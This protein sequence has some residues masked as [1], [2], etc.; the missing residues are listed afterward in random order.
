MPPPDSYNLAPEGTPPGPPRNVAQAYV[1]YADS[2][3]RGEPLA[4]DFNDAVSAHRLLDAIERS[5]N[6]GKSIKL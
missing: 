6:Q 1:R 5:A 3:P 2:L 4:P